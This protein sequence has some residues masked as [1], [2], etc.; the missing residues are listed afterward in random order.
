M[1][2]RKQDIEKLEKELAELDKRAEEL[3]LIDEPSKEI[4][5]EWEHIM[6]KTNKILK[7]LGREDEGYAD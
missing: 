6:Y 3:R 1:V 5:D 7:L 4:M 2:T